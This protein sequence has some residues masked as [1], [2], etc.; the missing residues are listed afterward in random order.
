M[1][2]FFAIAVSGRLL[3]TVLLTVGGHFLRDQ[4]YL[5]LS[6]L[7]GFAVVIVLLCFAYRD[8]LD[9]W[10]RALHERHQA[11]RNQRP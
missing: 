5:A 10:F 8:K 2:E 11:G 1:V 7:A 6:L 9:R 4:Q 3:G